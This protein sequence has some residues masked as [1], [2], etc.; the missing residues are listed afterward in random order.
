MGSCSN[1]SKAKKLDQDLFSKPLENI[2]KSEGLPNIHC[3][4]QSVSTLCEF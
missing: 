4:I 3:H 2:S 1:A